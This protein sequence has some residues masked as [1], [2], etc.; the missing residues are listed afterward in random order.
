VEFQLKKTV[1]EVM[2]DQSEVSPSNLPKREI[3]RFL[4]EQIWPFLPGELLGSQVSKEQEEEWL[5]FEQ[6]SSLTDET[7]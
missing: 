5:G 2:G 7:R 3:K 1:D 6:D 4:E